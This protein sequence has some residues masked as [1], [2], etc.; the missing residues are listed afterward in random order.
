MPLISGDRD[1]QISEFKASL[2]QSKFQVQKSLSSGVVVQAFDPRIQK[3][4]TYRSLSSIQVNLQS[5]FQD[6][7]G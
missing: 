1:K 2:V 5:K 7:Q 3:R 4:E 6:S